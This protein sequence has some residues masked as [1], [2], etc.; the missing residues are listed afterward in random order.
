MSVLHSFMM[1][2]PNNG[3]ELKS[4]GL[5]VVGN[6]MVIG[7]A[8]KIVLLVLDSDFKAIG[9]FVLGA[10]IGCVFIFASDSTMKALTEIGNLVT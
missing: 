5:V 10:A 4:W 9:K 6:L 8:A 2:A 7:C 3:A 1:A